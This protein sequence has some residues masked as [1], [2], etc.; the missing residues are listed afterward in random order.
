MLPSQHVMLFFV[1][2]KSRAVVL[3]TPTI[4][5]SCCAVYCLLQESCGCACDADHQH[6][7]TE[8][9]PGE[10]EVC[11]QGWLQ[12]YMVG[13]RQIN[14]VNSRY[15][16]IVGTIFYKFKLPEVQIN[17]GLQKSIRRQFMVGESNQNLF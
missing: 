2:Y 8:Y 5:I 15:L 11:A 7:S 14:T 4:S 13:C 9:H 6:H 16:E 17:L 12:C 10:T 1:Y 3:V